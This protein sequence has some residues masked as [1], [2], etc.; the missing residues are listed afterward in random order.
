MTSNISNTKALDKANNVKLQ[1]MSDKNNNKDYDNN[2]KDKSSIEQKTKKSNRDLLDYKGV[3]YKTDKSIKYYEFGAHFKYQELY[4]ILNGLLA[5]SEAETNCETANFTVSDK[6]KIPVNLISSDK[7]INKVESQK[8]P[9]I[10]DSGQKTG[11]Q[12]AAINN[13][14]KLYMLN[15]SGK[16]FK[17]HGATSDSININHQ[18]NYFND[19]E[20]DKREIS[21]I[22]Q[23]DKGYLKNIDK[24]QSQY[25]QSKLLVVNKEKKNVNSLPPINQKIETLEFVTSKIDTG[26]K[27]IKK[28]VKCKIFI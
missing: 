23:N 5:K 4:D 10:Q 27:N 2:E 8:P 13:K 14:N 1:Q 28:P 11:T 9:I 16:D 21:T 19:L 25:A 24:I 26:L 17:S 22:I 15:V 18:I 12:L 7:Q 6:N 20:K 3:H